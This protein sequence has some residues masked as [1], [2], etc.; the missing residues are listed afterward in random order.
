MFDKMCLEKKAVDL[1]KQAT[2][3]R[4]LVKQ[5][6]TWKSKRAGKAAPAE[7][8]IDLDIRRFEAEFKLRI[9]LEGIEEEE[10]E[11]EEKKGEAAFNLLEMKKK[12]AQTPTPMT[13]N[14]VCWDDDSTSAGFDSDTA[15]ETDSETDSETESEKEDEPAAQQGDQL[16]RKKKES[17]K[18]VGPLVVAEKK[19]AMTGYTS[20]EARLQVASTTLT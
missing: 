6:K 16:E 19:E 2:R 5:E 4:K 7:Q 18:Q 8:R 15:T 9:S 3:M 14:D 1:E 17:E 10:D 20:L 11:E 12:E 13:A